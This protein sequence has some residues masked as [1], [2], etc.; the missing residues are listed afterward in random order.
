MPRRIHLLGERQGL[1]YAAGIPVAAVGFDGFLVAATE[2]FLVQFQ[3][4]LLRAFG[5]VG[6]I[7]F[8]RLLHAV[9]AAGRTTPDE[10]L[11]EEAAPFLVFQPVDGEYLLAVHISQSENGLDAVEPLLELALVEQHHHIGVV[12]DGFLYYL[13]A[14]DVLYLLRHH[15]HRGP[16]LS[17]GLV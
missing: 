4:F 2:F 9:H 6:H 1:A 11:A 10:Y 3:R 13:A 7:A 17:C 15:A 5:G 12:D 14:D 16:E 8:V